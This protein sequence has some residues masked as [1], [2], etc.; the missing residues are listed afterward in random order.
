MPDTIIP[1]RKIGPVSDLPM[2]HYLFDPGVG[3]HDLWNLHSQC[4]AYA[5]ARSF[6]NPKREPDEGSKARAFG[7]ALHMLVLEGPA[8]FHAHYIAKP[9]GMSFSKKDGIEWRNREREHGNR[10]ILDAEDAT[11]II[12]IAQA[13]ANDPDAR[14]TLLQ[15][16]REVTLFAEDQATGLRIKSRPDALGIHM[17]VNIKTTADANPRAWKRQAVALGYHVSQAMTARV[18]DALGMDAKPYVFLVAEKA[19]NPIIELYELDD[20]LALL[21]EQIVDRSLRRWAKCMESGTWPKYHN[22]VWRIGA[23]KWDLD[24]IER[25]QTTEEME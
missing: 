7:T 14:R 11:M 24:E 8:K 9:E 10:I 4:P 20:N 23:D 13:V 22:G 21:G 2:D 16:E 6:S 3:G 1:P 25:M 15:T 5:W 19:R 12:N 18:M 17:A